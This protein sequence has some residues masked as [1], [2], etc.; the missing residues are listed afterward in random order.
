MG[1]LF[2]GPQILIVIFIIVLIFAAPKLPGLA[3]N[4][5]KSMKIFKSEVKS[6]RDDDDN[7]SDSDTESGEPQRPIEGNIVDKDQKSSGSTSSTRH[8]DS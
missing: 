8:T 5:G 7:E 1:R 3:K 6:L 4:L 2:D